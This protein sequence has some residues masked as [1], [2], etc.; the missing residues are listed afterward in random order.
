MEM[1]NITTPKRG[2][3]PKYTSE[4]ARLE[5]LRESKAK[6][7]QNNKEAVLAQKKDYCERH[8]AEKAAYDAARRQKQKA[9]RAVQN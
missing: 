4:E 9:E 6:W 1:E 5:A 7:Y 2:R 3:P 8:K